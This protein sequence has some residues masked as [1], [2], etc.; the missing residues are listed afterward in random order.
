MSSVKSGVFLFILGL[1]FCQFGMLVILHETFSSF[2]S[3]VMHS[4]PEFLGFI[5]QIFGSALI[6]FGI[7]NMISGITAE[8]TKVQTYK[9]SEAL[10]RIEGKVNELYF[11]QK[12]QRMTIC[13]FCGA[14]LDEGH[15]FCSACG[16]A[17][18]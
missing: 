3:G 9:L 10:Q 6:V 11:P 5:L 1:I 16:K 2:I 13:R 8:T 7:I 14:P 12:T 18:K 17:Q 4:Q 15:I